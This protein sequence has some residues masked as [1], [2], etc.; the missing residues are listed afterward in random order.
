[1]Q[2]IVVA[3]KTLLEGI[4]C[5]S[6]TDCCDKLISVGKREGESRGKGERECVRVGGWE[7]GMR[8]GRKE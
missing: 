3:Y 4:D 8:E 5:S 2:E 7:G 1:M 6:G